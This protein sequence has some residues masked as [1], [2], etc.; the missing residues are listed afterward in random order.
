[1]VGRLA[2]RWVSVN[3]GEQS[4]ELLKVKGVNKKARKQIENCFIK[5][6]LIKSISIREQV[7]LSH[8]VVSVAAA[9][10]PLYFIKSSWKGSNQLDWAMHAASASSTCD[11]W[12]FVLRLVVFSP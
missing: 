5:N 8:D 9:I 10:Q 7:R 4:R 6:E 3:D 12:L 1:M 11:P 2:G